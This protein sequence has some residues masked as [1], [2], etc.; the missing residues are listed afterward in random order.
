MYLIHFFGNFVVY[1]KIHFS[2]IKL[3]VKFLLI[4][5]INFEKYLITSAHMLTQE[6]IIRII[7]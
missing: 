7:S 5:I 2:K 4:L 1:V 6:K 3:F